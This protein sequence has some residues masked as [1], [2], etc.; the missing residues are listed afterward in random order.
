M[1]LAV[2]VDESR[3]RV[4]ES[5]SRSARAL[6]RSPRGDT[7]A[8]IQNRNRQ[9]VADPAR[10]P[11]NVPRARA[12]TDA[13]SDRVLDERLEQKARHHCRPHS[14][15]DVA[16]DRKAVLEANALDRDVPVEKS[17]LALERHLLLA[18][19]REDQPEEVAQLRY[20]AL[21]GGRIGGD[22]S[23]RAVERVEEEM[24]VQL[25]LQ[26]IQLR[27]DQARYNALALG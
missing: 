19:R 12:R 15:L 2:E 25:E 22:Q 17:Q 11:L 4:G 8:I 16:G 21:R 6:A 18:G 10:G 5:K 26:R 3:Y 9:L 24:R 27:L 20:H 1:A 23:H 7:D 13:M 14:V